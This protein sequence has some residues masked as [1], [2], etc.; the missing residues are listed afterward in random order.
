MENNYC[1]KV[2]IYLENSLLI[3]NCYYH[4]KNFENYEKCYHLSY[5]GIHL[6]LNT[7]IYYVVNL[8]LL[9]I[10]YILGFPGGSLVNNPPAKQET[11]DQSQCW[12]ILWKG[13]GN[14]LQYSCLGNSLDG[15]AW[16]TTTHGAAK[17][18]LSD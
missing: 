7:K 9:H 1:L 2:C 3:I 13:N 18:Q 17:G 5:K 16:R 6:L 14:P 12:K 8:Y 15:G 11:W 4:F 10:S